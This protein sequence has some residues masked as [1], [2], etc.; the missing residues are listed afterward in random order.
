MPVVASKICL[1]MNTVVITTAVNTR[2]GLAM[3]G[4]AEGEVLSVWMR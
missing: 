2:V 3:A 4:V 1:A